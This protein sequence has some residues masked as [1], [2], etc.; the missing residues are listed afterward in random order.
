[1]KPLI[2]VVENNSKSEEFQISLETSGYQVLRATNGLN[3]IRILSDTKQLP[4][5][6]ISEIDMPEMDGYDFFKTVSNNSFWN[7]IPFIFLTNRCSKEDIRYGKSLGVDDYITKPFEFEDILAIISGKISRYKKVENVNKKIADLLSTVKISKDTSISEENV[8][9]ILVFWDDRI[10]PILKDFYPQD[11]I[12][13]LSLDE[14][15]E[16]LFSGIET[17]YG[18]QTVTQ[19]DGILLNI[20][21]INNCGYI[22]FDSLPDERMRGGHQQY[23][24]GVIA[25]TITFFQTLKIKEVF[26]ELSEKIKIETYWDLKDYWDKIIKIL[27]KPS[28]L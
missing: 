4:D 25:P 2:L 26:K 1:M 12:K 3:A 5:L 11:K 22:F 13:L 7:S 19:A 14:L 17:M 6:I 10:G 23:M 8:V 9:I 21:N 18:T 24:I 28:V 15:A 20:E 16:Q 27:S